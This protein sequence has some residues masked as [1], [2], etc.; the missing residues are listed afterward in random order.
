MIAERFGEAAEVSCYDRKCGGYA[1]TTSGCYI[2][3]DGKK[4]AEY[5]QRTND[6][7]EV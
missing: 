5:R 7:K 2:Y 1:G 3:V 6:I 4:V